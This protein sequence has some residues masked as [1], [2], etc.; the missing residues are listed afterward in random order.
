MLSGACTVRRVA[1]LCRPADEYP[2]AARVGLPTELA[3][4]MADLRTGS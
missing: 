2:I 4:P 3:E 1:G